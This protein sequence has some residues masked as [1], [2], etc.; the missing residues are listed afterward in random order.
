M[1]S[2]NEQVFKDQPTKMAF[3]Q[4]TFVKS[5]AQISAKEK[6]TLQNTDGIRADW[7]LFGELAR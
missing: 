1:S 2:R 4:P 6:S 7:R 3:D 5:R